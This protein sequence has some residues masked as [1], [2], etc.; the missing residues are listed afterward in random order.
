MDFVPYS[1]WSVSYTHLDVYKRQV[2]YRV[3][4]RGQIIFRAAFLHD[5]VEVF[6]NVGVSVAAIHLF[7]PFCFPRLV[8]FKF[9]RVEGWDD[10]FRPAK[11]RLAIHE[12]LRPDVIVYFA[13]PMKFKMNV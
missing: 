9:L 8:L 6:E 1:S 5:L 7:S 10:N 4:E 3:M 2:I 11:L 12:M 13:F